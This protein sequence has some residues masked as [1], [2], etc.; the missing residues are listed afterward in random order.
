MFQVHK[1]VFLD[2]LAGREFD[3]F[4][5]FACYNC[6]SETAVF[7]YVTN[8]QMSNDVHRLR[9]YNNNWSG[10][11]KRSRNLYRDDKRDLCRKEE[12]GCSALQFLT[13]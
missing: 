7:S 12:L 4:F 3:T 13:E 6:L 11:G 8:L 10:S 9:L 5:M 2:V 1:R